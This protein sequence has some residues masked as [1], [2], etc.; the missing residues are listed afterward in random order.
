M[1]NIFKRI[2]TGIK[3]T[4]HIK[5]LTPEQK[6][7]REKKATRE[8]SYKQEISKIKEAS[9]QKAYEQEYQRQTLLYAE[10]QQKEGMS[11][12]IARARQ[13]VQAF[14]QPKQSWMGRTMGVIG[15][16]QQ[17]VGKVFP[18]PPSDAQARLQASMGGATDIALG[19]PMGMGQPR[20]YG[21]R[22]GRT[23]RYARTPNVTGSNDWV[24]RETG[25]IV[26]AYPYSAQALGNK[27]RKRHKHH[28]KHLGTAKGGTSVRI[29]GTTITLAGKPSGERTKHLKHRI[30]YYQQPQR[31]APDNIF[32]SS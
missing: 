24:S 28:L 16:F 29:N 20:A 31:T 1:Q 27:L 6:T 25:G 5:D 9:W 7:E 8:K 23:P 4:F 2:G 13:E 26:Q 3:T 12:G 32:W 22:Y 30:K 17:G 11:R 19:Q 10:Q 21:R 18:A 14:G 15:K